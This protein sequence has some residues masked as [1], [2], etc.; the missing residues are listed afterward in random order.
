MASVLTLFKGEMQKNIKLNLSIQSSALL[1][2][3]SAQLEQALINII[4]NAIDALSKSAHKEISLTL[5]QTDNSTRQ[6]LLLEIKDSGPGIVDHVKEQIFVPF[7]TTKNKG[8]G[9]GLSL[10]RQI[11]VQHGGDLKY[12]DKQNCGA[13]FRLAFGRF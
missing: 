7:F 4:K 1:M 3:D 5:Y 2:A 9:I 12:I 10:S 13:C 11:M 6:E 8:S